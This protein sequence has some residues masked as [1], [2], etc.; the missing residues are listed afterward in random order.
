[1]SDLVRIAANRLARQGKMKLAEAVKAQAAEI[2]RKDAALREIAQSSFTP[3]PERMIATKALSAGEGREYGVWDCAGCGSPDCPACYPAE[4][5]LCPCGNPECE[6]TH[7]AESADPEITRSV[8]DALKEWP[9][10]PTAES[11]RDHIHR[12]LIG[13]PCD[14]CGE[15]DTAEN[16]QKDE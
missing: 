10:L 13:K 7:K 12:G 4:S 5:V 6:G 8:L 2:E 14:I 16:R 9:E 1:M 3:T 11:G 15:P